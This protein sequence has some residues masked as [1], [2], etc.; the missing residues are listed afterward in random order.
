[1]LRIQKA[2]QEKLRK[3][4]NTP[5]QRPSCN[6]C[7]WIDLTEDEQESLRVLERLIPPH[8]CTKYGERVIHNS[9]SRTLNRDIYPCGDCI[10]DGYC[11]FKDRKYYELMRM[12]QEEYFRK[13]GQYPDKR[14]TTMVFKKRGCEYEN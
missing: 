10:N 14:F 7:I 1:M 2:I 13:Y 4:F 6:D 9:T 12:D 3:I 5:T 11:L 8:I